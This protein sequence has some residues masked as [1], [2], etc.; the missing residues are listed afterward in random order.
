[1]NPTTPIAYIAARTSLA[2]ASA[3]QMM[4]TEPKFGVGFRFTVDVPGLR[5]GDWQSCSG[6]KVKFNTN[7]VKPGGNHLSQE[8]LPDR[9]HYDNV[10]LKRAI[11]VTAS[12]KVQTWL[13][14]TARAWISDGQVTATTVTI[15]VYDANGKPVLKWVL[16][17]ARPVAW[18]GPELDASTSKLA[19]ETLELAHE[20]FE[21]L[22]PTGS[23]TSTPGGAQKQS[24]TISG[25]GGM[26]TFHAPPEKIS[27]VHNAEKAKSK[28]VVMD[29]SSGE[30]GKP[31][32]TQY[33]LNNLLLVGP[34]VAADIALLNK[35]ASF[36][37]PDATPGE[38][39]LGLLDVKWGKALPIGIKFQMSNMSAEY[40]RFKADG[41]PIRASVG[42]TLNEVASDTASGAGNPTS[43]G[44]P[45]R[46]SHV[47]GSTDSLAMLARE[48]YGVEG[49]WRDIAD[50]NGL[51]DPLRLR[52]GQ[53]LYLPARSELTVGVKG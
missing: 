21:V 39:A 18:S 3:R 29:P 13:N 9:V 43:G 25:E 10:V 17:K 33:K 15:M 8:F 30:G 45:G 41:T 14:Q 53:L 12:A 35:W 11:E 37:K 2:K 50:A 28:N 4:T 32:V 47:V 49:G 48:H 44:I 22:P 38:P 19:T 16:A 31:G 42:L 52:P 40:L 34:R 36:G 1:M 6:L 23:S 26:V 7:P 51:D 5:L 24:L 27:L 20:G 46:S